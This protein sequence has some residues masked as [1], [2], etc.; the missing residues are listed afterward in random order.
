MAA[1]QFNPEIMARAGLTD[2]DGMTQAWYVSADYQHI[3]GGAE[4]INDTLAHLWYF[5]PFTWLYRVPGIRQIEDRVYKWVAD[6]R[7]QMPGSTA[8]CAIN[9]PKPEENAKA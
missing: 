4:A 3:S 9:L 8:A 7:Y 5:R 1:W 6:H 2:E